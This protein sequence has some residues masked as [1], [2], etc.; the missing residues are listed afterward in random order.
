MKESRYARARR[1]RAAKF[2]LSRPPATP[3]WQE[4]RVRRR[5]DQLVLANLD[6]VQRMARKLFYSVTKTR[7]S[8]RIELADLQ[9]AGY[10]GLLQAATRFHPAMPMNFANFAHRRVYG[11]MVEVLRQ[12]TALTYHR[13]QVGAGEGQ[14]VELEDVHFSPLPSPEEWIR[15]EER[16]RVV[17]NAI[18][19]LPRRSRGL[20]TN[21]L[22]KGSSNFQY[23]RRHIALA[24]QQLRTLLGDV[25]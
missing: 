23:K 21:Y 5:R 13:G 17:H 24:R 25:A 7:M 14:F 15:S 11:E 12:L 22:I 20:V 3:G 10:V 2:A 9:Q 18:A 8:H 4:S 19:R 1:R 6:L 16:I